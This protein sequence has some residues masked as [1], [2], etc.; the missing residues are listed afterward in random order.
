MISWRQLGFEVV[1]DCIW[2]T[3]TKFG[4][5]FLSSLSPRVFI[6][7]RVGVGVADVAHGIEIASHIFVVRK[8]V[9]YP[10]RAPLVSG[11]SLRESRCIDAELKHLMLLDSC[12]LIVLHLL[13]LL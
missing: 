11:D 9:R 6:Y 1:M 8:V 3:P 4:T 12:Q 13:L 7:V 10:L 5:D 2:H